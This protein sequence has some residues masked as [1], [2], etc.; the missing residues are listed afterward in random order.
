MGTWGIGPFENDSA[1]ELL[2]EA[3]ESPTPAVTAALRAVAR[4]KAD[5]YLD[6]DVGAPAWAASE[7]VALAFGRGDAAGIPDHVRGI[8]EGLRPSEPQRV[9]ALAVIPRIGDRARSE[10][11]ALWHEGDDG[12]SFDAALAGLVALL[13]AAKDGPLELP[14]AKAGDVIIFPAGAGERRVVAGQVISPRE[15]AVLPGALDEGEALAAASTREARRVQASANELLRRGALLGNVPLRKELRGK[16][17]YAS[18][19]GG[20]DVY[21]VATASGGG[22]RRVS[23]EEARAHDVEEIL[24]EDAIR[25]VALG[26]HVPRRLR[27]RDEQVAELRVEKS[28]EWAE[29]RATTTPGPFGDVAELTGLLD[30]YEQYGAENAV[31]VFHRTAVGEQ[32]Y[33]RPEEHDERRS[34]AFAGLVA[35]WQGGLARD[36]W[37]KALASR[38]PAPPAKKLMPRALAAARLLVAQVITFDAELRLI[39]DDA[40]DGGAALRDAVA[41]LG[42][43]LGT[44]RRSR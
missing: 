32:G 38:F 4:A 12:A 17:L 36:A 11:A 24:G 22:L 13:E 20:L 14:K 33:G 10:L 1:A 7:L 9:L 8:L 6:V 30:W 2:E 37:P 44:E 41:S 35:L 27:S 34:F 21:F 26:S 15:L 18:E 19:A 28:A 25:A 39:W 3:A 40:P 16:K 42:E 29:R 43:A 5:A 31:D 23:F